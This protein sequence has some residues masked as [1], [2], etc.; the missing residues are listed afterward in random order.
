MGGPCI[1]E[2]AAIKLVSMA[3]LDLIQEAFSRIPPFPA[4]DTRL[5][6]SMAASCCAVSRRRPRRRP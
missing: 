5:K 3:L 6:A 4:I 1:M 2:A